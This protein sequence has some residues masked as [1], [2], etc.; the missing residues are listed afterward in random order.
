M[1]NPWGKGEWTGDWS[2]TS[3]KW[4]D[5]LRNRFKLKERDDGLFYMD[6]LD[7]VKHFH[8]TTL[9]MEWASRYKHSDIHHQFSSDVGA[10]NQAFFSFNIEKA[11]D[12]NN[13]AFGISVI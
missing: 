12:F 11:I 6:L 1:R 5:S 2:D 7:Y 3:K 13:T 10:K 4:N 9:G 8:S